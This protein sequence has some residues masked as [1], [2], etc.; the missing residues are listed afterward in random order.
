MENYG[1]DTVGIFDE[2]SMR[3][4]D[5]DDDFVLVRCAGLVYTCP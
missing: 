4:R 3:F 2:I 1:N 5:D